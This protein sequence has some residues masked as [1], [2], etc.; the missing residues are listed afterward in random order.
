MV[1]KKQQAQMMQFSFDVVAWILTYR[2]SC[3]SSDDENYARA[4]VSVE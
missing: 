1:L 4:D 2:L 3:I